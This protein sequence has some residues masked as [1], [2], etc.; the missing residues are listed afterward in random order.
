MTPSGKLH[1]SESSRV[2]GMAKG[3]LKM[4][5]KQMIKQYGTKIDL[6]GRNNFRDGDQIQNFAK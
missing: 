1:F 2:S 3:T 4:L 5:L 6:N